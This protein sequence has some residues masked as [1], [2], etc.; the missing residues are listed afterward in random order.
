MQDIVIFGAGSF[1]KEVAQLVKDINCDKTEWN[2]L[3]FI[4][5]LPEKKG[6]IINS[7]PVLGNMEWL[8][9]NSGQD[10]MIVCAVANPRGKRSIIERLD[11]LGA[12]YANLIHPS[13]I[14]N[15]FIDIGYGNIICCNSILSVNTRIGNHVALNPGCGVGHDTIIEDYSTLYWDVTL[16]GSV[17]INEGC[18]IGSKSVVISHKS[19]GR[20]SILGAGAVAVKDIPEFCTA[21][22]V[23]AK[24]IKFYNI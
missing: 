2:L 7:C 21:V 13:V 12:R 11:K 22:G 4:D 14:R 6:A 8:E 15:D 9:Q 23:P 10:I 17:T 16:S 20:W 18:E 5:E 3:G 19:I 1:G 24:P